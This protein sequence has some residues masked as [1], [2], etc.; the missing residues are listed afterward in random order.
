MPSSVR[1]LEG[2]GPLG[3]SSICNT[4][5]LADAVRRSGRK[6]MVKRRHMCLIEISDDFF[7]S[8]LIPVWKL[9]GGRPNAFGPQSMVLVNLVKKINENRETKMDFAAIQ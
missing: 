5:K 7:D 3:V 8:S 9:R 4:L 2:M 6:C 1:T